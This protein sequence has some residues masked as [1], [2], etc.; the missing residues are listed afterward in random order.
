MD[1]KLTLKL[2]K[3]IIEKAKKYAQHQKQSLSMLV[4]DYFRLLVSE[5]EDVDVELSPV[6]EELAGIIQL[7][8]GFDWKSDYRKYVAEKYR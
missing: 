1:T 2:D 7:D 8:D 5:K 4:E 6:V 3:A